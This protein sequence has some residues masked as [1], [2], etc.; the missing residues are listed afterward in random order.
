[1]D[2]YVVKIYTYIDELR[3]R[4]EPNEIYGDIAEK[5]KQIVADLFKEKGWEGDGEIKLIWIPPFLCDNGSTIGKYVWHVKQSNNGISYLAYKGSFPFITE[6]YQPIDFVD[7]VLYANVDSFKKQILNYQT[8][9]NKIDSSIDENLINITVNGFHADIIASFNEFINYFSLEIFHEL[10]LENN[11]YKLKINYKP[12]FSL[13]IKNIISTCDGLPEG[14]Y[15][16]NF[17]FQYE[18]IQSLYNNF[19][20][21]P[22][23]NRIKVVCN[24]FD[25]DFFTNYGSELRKQV[26]IRNA[27]QHREGM[28]DKKSYD[29]IGSKVFIL[30]EDGTNKEYKAFET[31]VLTLAEVKKFL[32]IL[33]NFCDDL[34]NAIEQKIQ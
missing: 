13:S 25:F 3:H 9:L 18:L 14:T 7:T 5:E 32:N 24:A 2:E 11:P 20:F 30:Q 23:E 19:K 22:Y 8:I 31:V 12:N 16:E 34:K 10:I 29:S 1:M 6:D 27:F 26:E 33:D 15:D 4:I 28:L 17:I 21:E